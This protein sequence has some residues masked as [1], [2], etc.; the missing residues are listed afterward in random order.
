MLYGE[1]PEIQV[2]IDE[3]GRGCM[4]GPVIAAAVIWDPNI[5]GEGI[6]DSKKL[7]RKKRA[8]MRKYIEEHAIAYGVGMASSVEIDDIN[9]LNATYLAMHRALDSI[10]VPYDRILVDGD[11][12]RSYTKPESINTHV[13]HVCLPSG[14]DTYVSIAAA[15][16]LAKEVHDDWIMEHYGSDTLYDLPNNR[17]YGTKRH[18]EGLRSHGMTKDHR[19][20]FQM[21]NKKTI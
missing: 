1:S 5:S 21:K 8:E 7:S 6:K 11:R 3:A 15:S 2:G 17:G 13:P 4:I 16:I 9:I 18:M 19:R 10:V 12:F 14:D 20:S